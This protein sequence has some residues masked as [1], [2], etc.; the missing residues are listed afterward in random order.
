[1]I[2]RKS[3]KQFYLSVEGETEKW[4]FQHLQALI[5]KSDNTKYLIALDIKIN[6]N[7]KSFIKAHANIFPIKAFHIFDY[8]SN[9]PVHTISFKETL[10]LLKE[11]KVLKGR[12]LAN[13]YKAGYSNYCF[14]LWIV[15]H[16]AQLL[17]P[18]A[19]RKDY[20]SHINKSY[21]TNFE[22]VKKYKAEKN[23]KQMLSQ[24]TLPDVVQAIKFAKEIRD[25]NKNIGKKIHED[26][27]FKYY[28]D[29]PDLTIHECVEEM[30][31]ECGLK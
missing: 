21:G 12:K 1:M 9:D 19:H 17:K 25:K 20:I 16:K 10:K 28:P 4:Y 8:E 15:L 3:N 26:Y 29:N 27:G 23:F 22:F 18:L 11:A 6:K 24:I 7:P 31:R 5:N 13:Y 14:D 2:N 30:L